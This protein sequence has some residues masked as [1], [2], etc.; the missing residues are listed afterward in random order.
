MPTVYLIEDFDK[1][2]GTRFGMRFEP[3]PLGPSIRLV[4]VID[5][6]QQQIVGAAMHDQADIAVDAQRA[7]IWIARR[8]Q[9]VKLHTRMV[10]IKLQIERRSLNGLLLIAG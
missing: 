9:L 4:V 6:A 7:E 10:R 8:I 5:V 3:A 2:R 1:L